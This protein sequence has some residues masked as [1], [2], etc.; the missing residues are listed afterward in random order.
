MLARMCKLQVYE[1]VQIIACGD[2]RQLQCPQNQWKGKSVQNVLEGSQLLASMYPTHVHLQG[3]KRFDAV[4]EEYCSRVS[5]QEESVEDLVAAGRQT[6][7]CAGPWDT[8][9]CVTHATRQLI[10]QK[11][12]RREAR[13]R[14]S[15]QIHGR[16]GLML[17]WPG[18]RLIGTGFSP[19]VTTGAFYEVAE[20]GETIKLVG[21]IELT[22][23]EV[24]KYLRLAHAITIDSSQSKTLGGKIRVVESGHRHMTHERLLVAASRATSSEL[25]AI[26]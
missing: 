14:D 10:N 16:D 23:E 13:G 3:S 20:A 26:H 18:L 11:T 8:T 12:N 22:Q 1:D 2:P 5:R 17:L 6:F 25:L 24:G 7:R 21:D 15:V 19:K 4:L 9:I